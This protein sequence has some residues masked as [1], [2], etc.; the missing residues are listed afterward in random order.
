LDVEG[1]DIRTDGGMKFSYGSESCDNLIYTSSNGFDFLNFQSSDIRFSTGVSDCSAST[2]M[3]IE[4]DGDVGI[5]TTTPSSTLHIKHSNTTSEGLTLQNS[6]DSDN[7]RWRV[8]SG[9]F[10]YLYF[11][12][13][14][15]GSYNSTTGLYTASSDKRLK[16]SINRLDPVL[17]DILRLSPKRYYFKSDKDRKQKYIGFLA[18]DVEKIFPSLTYYA[19]EADLY[20]LDYSGFGVLAIK[21]IQEQQEII[22]DQENRINKLENKV[23]QLQEM[24]EKIIASKIDTK[25]NNLIVRLD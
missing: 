8:T 23:S 18:Q 1:G 21:A 15:R 13:A 17:E 20:T 5:G 12:G 9:T 14:Y 6:Y 3:I 7:W 25:K 10:L 4:N 19:E 2:R 16:T 11:N 22:E 24:V